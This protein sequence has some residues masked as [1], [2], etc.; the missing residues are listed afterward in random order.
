MLQL[1]SLVYKMYPLHMPLI[2]HWFAVSITAWQLAPPILLTAEQDTNP[3]AHFNSDCRF[4]FLSPIPNLIVYYSQILVIFCNFHTI[5]AV[6][7]LFYYN[8]IFLVTRVPWWCLLFSKWNLTN[9]TYWW[10]K[11][12]L[13]DMDTTLIYLKKK[14]KRKSHFCVLSNNFDSC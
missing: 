9:I 13:N 7:N 11:D 8:K 4:W 12:K 10:E 3:M 2:T 14:K 5:R 1:Y 6:A